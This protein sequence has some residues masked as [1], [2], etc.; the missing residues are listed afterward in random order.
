MAL[1]RNKLY[2]ILTIACVAGYSWLYISMTNNLTESKSVEV[3][4]IKH[5]T[6]IPCPSCG[7]TRSIMSMTKGDFVGALNVNPIG[8]IVA[9][10][11]L[12]APIWIVVDL[13]MKN[14]TLFNTYQKMETLLKRPT[15]AIPLVL[16]VIINWI[17]N[18]AKGL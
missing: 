12:M 10:I 1:D 6:N 9:L 5:V 13:I 7:S 4:L 17:W 3:C 14:N 15:Y 8:Y 2:S 18:I 16:L 11:M